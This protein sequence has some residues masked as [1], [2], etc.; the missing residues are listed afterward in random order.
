MPARFYAPRAVAVVVLLGSLASAPVYAADAAAPAPAAVKT[1]AA[2]MHHK[3]HEHESVEGMRQHVEERIKTLHT[4]LMITPEQESDWND[5]AQAMRDSEAETIAVIHERHNATK[6]L[7]AVEDMESYQKIA[8]AHA[9]GL[10]KVISAFSTLYDEMSDAQKANA[11]K[12]FGSY[13]GHE[14]GMHKHMH[15]M[16]DAKPATK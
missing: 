15:K 8:Q 5:V 3:H 16:H 4:K 9:D 2:P 13:E 10:E 14:H 12:I 7:N 11:D 1:T 6:P